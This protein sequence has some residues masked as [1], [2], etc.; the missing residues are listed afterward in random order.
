MPSRDG[1]KKVGVGLKAMATT[2]LDSKRALIPTERK[3]H[4]NF[5]M[6][7]ARMK[8]QLRILIIQCRSQAV[9]DTT[10]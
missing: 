5:D 4:A 2:G 6:A 1:L 3:K 7:A 9:N 10:Q 8:V